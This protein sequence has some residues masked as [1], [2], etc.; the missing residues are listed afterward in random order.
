MPREK[1]VTIDALREHIDKAKKIKKFQAGRFQVGTRSDN[2][3]IYHYPKITK[4]LLAKKLG[5]S[6]NYLTILQKKNEEISKV[7]R[8]IGQPRGAIGLAIKEEPKLN[9]KAYFEQKVKRLAEENEILKK[10]VQD[11]RLR[12][13]E[14]KKTEMQ[15]DEFLESHDKVLEELTKKKDEV[16]QLTSKI[17]GL[18][19][20]N[21][22]LKAR[23]VL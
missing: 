13:L 8:Y 7:L 4:A 14:A 6:A 12:R 9:T 5:V 20:E 2:Q 23:L 1:I 11:F 21:A 15:I 10:K 22:S 3:P 19:M 18:E 17:R 16:I